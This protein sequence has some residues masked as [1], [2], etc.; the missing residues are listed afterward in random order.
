MKKQLAIIIGL[1][2]V[3]FKNTESNN[4]IFQLYSI[5]DN[6]MLERYEKVVTHNEFGIRHSIDSINYQVIRRWN[7]DM[8]PIIE[9][10]S[11]KLTNIDF[12]K[13]YHDNGQ[14]KAVGFKTASNHTFIGRWK[15]YSDSGKLDS[16]VDYDKKYKVSFCDFYQIA[17]NNRMTGKTSKINFNPDKRVWRVE[18]WNYEE[19]SATGIEL[20]VDSMTIKKIELFRIN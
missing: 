2:F 12:D 15:Y 5:I 11:N 3:S 1:V 6:S 10:I 9:S 7:Y 8:I 13:E 16:V 18:K 14:L 17:E 20:Q 4:C 19:N